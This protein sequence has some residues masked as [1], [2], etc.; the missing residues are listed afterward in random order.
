MGFPGGA[1]GKEPTCK[2]RRHKRCGFHPWVRRS[3]WGEHDNPLQYSCLENSMNRGAWQA[4]VH[5]IVKSWTW[6]KW[7]STHAMQYSIKFTQLQ[8]LILNSHFNFIYLFYP[9]LFQM[10]SGIYFSLF[11]LIF[12]KCI[13]TDAFELENIKWNF[14]HIKCLVWLISITVR[15]S[16][17]SKVTVSRKSPLN[18]LNQETLKFCQMN[19]KLQ[20]M[21]KK[22]VL[23]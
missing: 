5:W 14:S 11:F 18:E 12:L 19:K 10:L 15:T 23:H 9:I 6:M 1:S 3:P 8:L 13:L 2:Y 17:I 21:K 22:K 16:I 7:L 4:S 20:E